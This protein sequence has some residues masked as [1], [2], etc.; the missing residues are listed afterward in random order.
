[1]VALSGAHTVRFSHCKEFA[2][3]IFNHNGGGPNAFDPSMNPRFAQALQKTCGNYVKDPT[4]AVFNDIMTPGKFNNIYYQNLVKGLGLLKSD[5]NLL[6]N[7]RTAPI[8][9]EYA[10]DQ[11]VFFNDFAAAM[12]KLG[13]YRVKTESNG[14]TRRRCDVF[15]NL[16]V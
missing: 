8:V 7:P 1:M 2:D 5:Q 11:N 6:S 4:M 13:H 3:R 9:T 16:K 14:E 10:K 15:N 12:E